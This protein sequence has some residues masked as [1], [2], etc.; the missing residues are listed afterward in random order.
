MKIDPWVDFTGPLMRQGPLEFVIVRVGTG[1]VR[2]AEGNR[3]TDVPE[4]AESEVVS[5]V[6]HEDRIECL[7]DSG[8]TAVLPICGRDPL[9]TKEQK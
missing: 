1:Y 8:L 6:E 9:E 7:L 5:V 3:V 2:D 4:G